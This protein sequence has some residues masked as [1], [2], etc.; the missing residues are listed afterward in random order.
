MSR[1]ETVF[2]ADD[3]DIQRKLLQLNTKM[4]KLAQ[5]TA[6]TSASASKSIGQIGNSINAIGPTLSRM[7]G[8]FAAA[9]STQEVIALADQFTQFQAKL[10]NAKVAASDMARV[11]KDLFATAKANGQDIVALGDLYGSMAKSAKSLGLNQSE[12][13]AATEGV[14]AAMRL[15]GSTTAQASATI[16][17]LG[18]ALVGGTVRAEEFNSMLENAPALVSAVAE[19]SNR[20]KGD[21]GLLRREINDGKVSSQQWAD[22]IVAASAKLKADAAN[23]PLTVAAAIQNLRT[24]MIEY[25]GAA[26]QSLGASAKLG[27]ALKLLGDN[28]GLVMNSLMVIAAF[29]AGRAAA[30]MATWAAST[31]IA[32][33]SNLRYQATLAGMMAAQTGVA[34]TSL[35][36]SAAM[37]KLNASM[38]FFGGPL[39]LAITAVSAAIIGFGTV[40]RNTTEDAEEL[41]ASLAKGN[42]VLAEADRIL[43]KTAKGSGDMGDKSAGA[44]SGVNG[45]CDATRA[46][47]D[48]TYRLADAQQQAAR[49]ALMAQMEINRTRISELSNPSLTRRAAY[50]AGM[51]YKDEYVKDID[52]REIDQRTS[53]NADLMTRS[54][55]LVTAPGAR[56][57][58]DEGGSGV[59]ATGSGK[60][61]GGRSGTSAADRDENDERMLEA[62]RRRNIEALNALAETSDQRHGNA[63]FMIDLEALEIEK[64]I[65]KQQADKKVSE[66]AATEAL[67]V[68]ENTRLEERKGELKRRDLE[69]EQERADLARELLDLDQSLSAIQQETLRNRSDIAKTVADRAALEDAEFALFQ[70]SEKASFDARQAETRA[71]LKLADQLTEEA[72]RRLTNEAAAFAA[73]QQSQGDRRND[74]KRQNNPFAAYVDK[75]ADIN[76]QFRDIA[77][78]GLKSFEDGIVS[79]MMQTEKLGDV[80]KNVAKQIIADLI[81]IAVRKAIVGAISNVLGMSGFGGGATPGDNGGL[82]P[83]ALMGSPSPRAIGDRNFKG[84]LAKVGESGPEIVNLPSGTQIM[85]NFDVRSLKAPRGSSRPMATNVSITN[86]VHAD[87]AL[88]REDLDRQMVRATA[89][90][91]QQARQQMFTDLQNRERN[92]IR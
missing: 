86:V 65:K 83:G 70:Q 50:A 75:A 52:Q 4:E 56:L 24:S 39:G 48:E 79:A 9:F 88:V 31:V 49:T 41:S 44:V 64:A 21:L 26:D 76:Q 85:P 35:L 58:R 82:L 74:E 77:S 80:F 68:N 32:T 45:L 20:W 2:T 33:A 67:R 87:N 73:L 15:S 55:G 30:G 18:Q 1:V 72:E 71:R 46:L 17:Q 53:Q 78:D 19:S 6:K 3:R 22:A 5:Q 8:V 29:L 23:A 61:G 34:R 92:R 7:G 12:M 66:E 13:M 84:G 14:A 28:I 89:A 42:E 51:K 37:D 38:A 91:M 36:A 43:A 81:R 90:G 25:I 54:I 63:L 62:A 57:I 47:A 27:V 69:V 60:G 59:N 10:I 40:A 16:L 11:Q